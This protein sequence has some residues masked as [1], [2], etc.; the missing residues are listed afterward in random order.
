MC[1][2]DFSISLGLMARKVISILHLAGDRFK[3]ELGIQDFFLFVGANM[4]KFKLLSIGF[5][6]GW[7]M[8]PF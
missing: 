1:N 5:S 6:H 2:L 7:W 3:V 4:E 8:F